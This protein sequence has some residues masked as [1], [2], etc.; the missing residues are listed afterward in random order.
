VRD[1][2]GEIGAVLVVG[3]QLLDREKPRL[4]QCRVDACARVALAQDEAVAA[5]PT[6]LVRSDPQDAAVE[7]GD[8][9]GQGEHGA[10]M[11]AAP[12]ARHLDRVTSDATSQL[13]G[14]DLLSA[15]GHLP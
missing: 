2:A 4:G 5:G 3:P 9:V 11:G 12:T 13:L 15:Q 10:D 1:V 14:A 6:R 7:Y 8:D